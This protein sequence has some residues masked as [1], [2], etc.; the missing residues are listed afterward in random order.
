MRVAIL[1]DGVASRPESAP[2]ELG[3]LEAVEAVDVALR[4]LGHA[5]VRIEV[6]HALEQWSGRLADAAA[7]L[8]F[9]LCEALAGRSAHEARVAA[10]VELLGLP[11]TGSASDVLALA[12]R[13][14]RVNALLAAAGLP[15]PVWA[16]AD[17][18]NASCWWR[19]PAIVKPAGE[20]A[21]VGITSR[22]VAA[23]ATELDAALA[24]AAA[25]APLLIQDFVG[26]RELNVGIVGDE[27]LPIGE[28]EFG[29]FPEG[30]WPVVSYE[31]KWAPGSAEDLATTP[32]CPAD[33]DPALAQEARNLA[34][35][36]WRVIGGR[37]YGRVDLRAD[38]DGR[39]FVLDVNPNPDL[40]PS[41]GLTR[42][43]AA[44]GWGY[45]ELIRRIVEEAT[46]GRGGAEAGR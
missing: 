29:G 14:D 21:S 17:A 31:A 46:P 24:A 20:H 43:A 23:N 10:V 28:I 7:E 18:P 38:T 30:A 32:R 40:A 39:L 19:F 42:M 13:K 22:S 4:D 36:A 37:G 6:G 26:G 12:V 34:L 33:L 3:V 2:D 9:N 27:V 16:A 8:V 15:V 1:H 44:A 45:A 35:A 5:P 25:H 41:A 11:M